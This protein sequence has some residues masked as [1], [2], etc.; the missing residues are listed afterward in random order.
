MSRHHCVSTSL[1]N[2][3]MRKGTFIFP[4]RNIA[5]S[6]LLHFFCPKSIL[7]L[8]CR[9]LTEIREYGGTVVMKIFSLYYLEDIYAT[10]KYPANKLCAGVRGYYFCVAT[11]TNELGE[12]GLVT[13]SRL[14]RPLVTSCTLLTWAAGPLCH[15]LV[16]SS[17]LLGVTTSHGSP[18]AGRGKYAAVWKSS[19]RN[20]IVNIPIRKIPDIE[21]KWWPL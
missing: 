7:L 13:K 15:Y 6:E 17:P 5:R 4:V 11:L 8:E 20:S 18:A 19:Q 9:K 21:F 3:K 14:P 10:I 2:V 16:S 1:W 12:V